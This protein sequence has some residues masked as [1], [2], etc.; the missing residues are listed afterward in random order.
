MT[1]IYVLSLGQLVE[2]QESKSVQAF[3]EI[4]QEQKGYSSFWALGIVYKELL[5]DKIYHHTI[6]SYLVGNITTDEFKVKLSSQLGIKETDKFCLAWNAMCEFSEETLKK[7]D[8]IISLQNKVHFE[9]QIVS[10]TNPM[11][12]YF[13]QENL[14]KNLDAQFTHSFEEGEKS[15]TELTKISIARNALDIIG[16]NIILVHRA[17][18]C[19]DLDLDYAHCSSILQQDFLGNL[20]TETEL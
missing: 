19:E 13:I 14:D 9:V 7:I 17:I 12:F 16:N 2:S 1:N 3:S 11:Q 6:D 15:L 4:L 20:E 18:K 10:T 8:N 5:I